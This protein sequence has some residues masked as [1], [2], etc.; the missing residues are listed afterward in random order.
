MKAVILA[1]GKGTRLEPLT[2]TMPKCMLPLAGKPILEHIVLAMRGAGIT[3]IVMVVGYRSEDIMTYF[4]DGA[5][6]GVKLSY[7]TQEEKLGTAHALSMARMEEDFLALNGDTLISSQTLMEVLRF[8]EGSATLALKRMDDPRNYGAVVLEGNRVMKL[9]EK[10]E[11][12]ISTLINAGIYAFSPEIF[13]VIRKTEKSE[14]GEYELTSSINRL[15]DG[16][17]PPIGVEIKGLWEDVGTPWNHLDANHAALDSM[18]GSIQS[19]AEDNVKIKGSLSLGENSIIRSGCYIEGPVFIGDDCVIGPNAYLRAYTTIGKGCKIGNGVEVK[20][21]IIMDN[22]KVPHLSYVG[23]SVIGRNCN[24]GAGTKVGNLRMD[25]GM[26]K[27]RV[28]GELVNTGRKKLGCVIGDNVKTGL[29]VMIN[30][31]RK[32]G[33]SSLIGPGVIVY[34]D[35]KAGSVVLK[36]QELEMR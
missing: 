25:E 18:E 31:G 6:Y 16:G 3:D 28:K 30:A 36:K 5:D 32:I 9:V 2:N 27:M 22:T 34:S 13:D 8:H 33:Q 17:N 26:V 24:L 21:S 23:D 4:G 35:I 15:I 1:A 7:V 19:E 14:R 10:P 29:N 20:N 12:K 11:K